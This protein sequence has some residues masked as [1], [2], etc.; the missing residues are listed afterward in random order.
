MILTEYDEKKHMQ[1]IAEENREEGFKAGNEMG[2]DRFASLS[3]L[4]L[5]EKRIDDLT[6]ASNDSHYRDELIK[7]YNI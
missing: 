3:K 6:R 4:L 2:L 1:Q 7:Q 5:S